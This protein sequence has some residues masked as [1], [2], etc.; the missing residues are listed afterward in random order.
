MMPPLLQ[1]CTKISTTTNEYGDIVYSGS[2]NAVISCRFRHI[3]DLELG[4][5]NRDTENADA[6]LW[7]AADSGLDIGSVILF[8]SEYWRVK[9]L[10]K[11]R[12]L[13]SSDVN[14]LKMTLERQKDTANVS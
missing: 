2:G 12:K 6:M 14:F 3:T 9:D 5:Q 11:A 4:E 7:T 10:I 8:E 1:S 13:H